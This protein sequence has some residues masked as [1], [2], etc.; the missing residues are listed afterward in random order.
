MNCLKQDQTSL[1]CLLLL[2][3]VIFVL[4]V[5]NCGPIAVLASAMYSVLFV[6]KL[7]NDW[8]L[9]KLNTMSFWLGCFVI[10]LCCLVA[11]FISGFVI[12]GFVTRNWI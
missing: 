6:S 9:Q 1:L 10:T 12:P 8:I 2:A 4:G 3:P 7:C 11:G 5:G